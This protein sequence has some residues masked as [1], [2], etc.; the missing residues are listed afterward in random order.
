MAFQ[1]RKDALRARLPRSKSTSHMLDV[2]RHPL[3]PGE[4]VINAAH[5]KTNITSLR[6]LAE[7]LRTTG[8]PS[9]RS[10]SPEDCVR[11]PGSKAGGR[12]SVQALRRS[13]RSKSRTQ[14]T[15]LKLSDGA[16]PETTVDGHNHIALYTPVTYKQHDPW[17]RSQHPIPI[18]IPGSCPVRDCLPQ[19]WPERTTSRG[20][21]SSIPN[22]EILVA[23][24]TD[25]KQPANASSSKSLGNSQLEPGDPVRCSGATSTTD[26][27][28]RLLRSSTGLETLNEHHPRENRNIIETPSIISNPKDI[29]GRNSQL[30]HHLPGSQLREHGELRGAR[31][32]AGP[33][34]TANAE[35]VEDLTDKPPL[36]EL[37]IGPL[38]K[39]AKEDLS[40]S[41]PT[42]AS[43]PMPPNSPTRTCKKPTEITVRST[44][45]VPNKD[46]LLPESPGFPNML[47]ALTFPSPPRSSRSPSPTDSIIF[48]VPNQPAMVPCSLVRPRISS[49]RACTSL[50]VPTVSLDEIIMEP[51]RP[52]LRHVKS[53]YPALIPNMLKRCAGIVPITEFAVLPDSEEAP[54]TRP[55]PKDTDVGVGRQAVSPVSVTFSTTNTRHEDSAL[56]NYD[57]DVN[58]CR[59]SLASNSTVC[60]SLCWQS[61]TTND[62]HCQ[63]T[64][65]DVTEL[66]APAVSVVGSYKGETTNSCIS[67]PSA[68]VSSIVDKQLD[69]S[70]GHSGPIEDVAWKGKAEMP[71]QHPIGNASEQDGPI[72]SDTPFA[73]SSSPTQSRMQPL[74]R[75]VGEHQIGLKDNVRA[76]TIR[77]V[78]PARL[79]ETASCFEARALE[80]MD[81]PVLGRFPE[82]VLR[83]SRSSLQ[84]RSPLAQDSHRF[85]NR[86]VTMEADEMTEIYPSH[87]G[88]Q[89][90]QECSTHPWV[91]SSDW[92]VS[93]LMVVDIAPNYMA[94]LPHEQFSISP[95]MIVANLESRPGPS[96]FRLP[97]LLK[98]DLPVPHLPP[99]SSLRPKALKLVPQPRQKLYPITIARNPSTG[100]IERTTSA[101]YRL[102]RHSL[103]NMP[104]PPLSPE[105]ARSSWRQ[106]LPPKPQAI[107]KSNTT[108][109][110]TSK[111]QEKQWLPSQSKEQ[112]QDS[113]WRKAALKE[114]VLREKQEK[115]KEISDIVARTVGSSSKEKYEDQI[116]DQHQGNHATQNIERRLLRLERNGDAWLRA[117]KPFLENIAR[118]LENMRQ[119]GVSGSLTM[120]EFN[121]DMEAEA[122]RVSCYN[123]PQPGE[124]VGK[125]GNMGHIDDRSV[126]KGSEL[127]QGK[128]TQTSSVCIQQKPYVEADTADTGKMKNEGEEKEPLTPR[129]LVEAI[130]RTLQEH[131]LEAQAAIKRRLLQQEAMM[132]NLLSRWGLPSPRLQGSGDV[133]GPTD[134]N[135][136]LLVASSPRGPIDDA[137]EGSSKGTGS[138]VSEVEDI[139]PLITELRRA[140]WPRRLDDRSSYG[141]SNNA[142]GDNNGV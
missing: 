131:E 61:A 63:S 125:P 68:H 42:G 127:S 78:D 70:L 76:Y 135:T 12:W 46:P 38:P 88:D 101:H 19:K 114:R 66:S 99:R 97:Q 141:E 20:P 49:R 14:S 11:L 17:L 130:P 103:S 53:E 100:A 120:N 57:D 74:P 30:S 29:C 104:T 122:R 22:D 115:E 116:L 25:L 112:E 9:C 41:I 113:R 84:G 111:L 69:R 7:F 62:S 92:A 56:S 93:P 102:N 32:G 129:P 18:P 33:Q 118:T 47:A 58:S 34:I 106:S 8:P 39:L 80:S 91:P 13:R 67:R 123:Q 23:S 121:I 10:T 2:I 108:E 90:Y 35:G 5:E 133:I 81:S 71:I 3:G 124:S 109:E 137:G 15:Q 128:E 16:V 75:S 126:P 28:V 31:L 85:L 79:G 27:Q 60:T 45:A 95:I 132:S 26:S 4:E 82:N 110:W 107:E 37:K 142:I 40:S 139:D 98:S 65:C 83:P 94:S 87:P 44:L 77:D 117:L 134:A 48:P 138:D 89:P 54:S 51:K 24:Q 6:E 59:Q 136:N 1:G 50:S 86:S 21:V 64:R 72:I 36:S 140:P 105:P 96:T 55:R 73:T 52:A 43:E 119:D